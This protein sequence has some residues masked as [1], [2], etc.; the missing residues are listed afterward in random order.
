MSK[1]KGRLFDETTIEMIK[2]DLEKEGVNNPTV[3]QMIRFVEEEAMNGTPKQELYRDVRLSNSSLQAHSGYRGR[4][5]LQSEGYE[6]GSTSY[7]EDLNAIRYWHTDG[8][9]RVVQS[10]LTKE[11]LEEMLKRI[12]LYDPTNREEL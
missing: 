5:F 12:H 9:G 11:V 10:I 7:I 1:Y 2:E 8:Y 6:R 3:A 4:R